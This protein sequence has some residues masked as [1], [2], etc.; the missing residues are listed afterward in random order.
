M[1]SDG[2]CVNGVRI[3]LF[4][5]FGDQ[6]AKIYGCAQKLMKLAQCPSRRPRQQQP[7]K[8]RQPQRCPIV[9]D[10]SVQVD[11]NDNDNKRE[12]VRNGLNNGREGSRSRNGPLGANLR[13]ADEGGIASPGRVRAEFRARSQERG[14]GGGGGDGGL[15]V[16]LEPNGRATPIGSWTGDSDGSRQQTTAGPTAA[17]SRKTD[18]DCAPT[19]RQS[20]IGDG[21]FS[22]IIRRR[23]AGCA[24]RYQSP[25]AFA[26]APAPVAP[27]FRQPFRHAYPRTTTWP[28]LPRAAHGHY[29]RPNVPWPGPVL[30]QYQR[31]A[32]VPH[33]RPQRPPPGEPWWPQRRPYGGRVGH[34]GYAPYTQRVRPNWPGQAGSN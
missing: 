17:V 27:I 5:C 7:S 26:A 29:A 4:S 32:F 21:R 22:E 10:S 23:R 3:K 14:G 13:H 18:A 34:A 2:G 19:E 8:P 31:H 6:I 15:A 1:I 28:T 16:D 20:E 25:L 12:L 24:N 30:G 9:S 33:V 11:D